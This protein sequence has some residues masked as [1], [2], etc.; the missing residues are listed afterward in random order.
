M[1]SQMKKSIFEE[2]TAKALKKWH[3]AAKQRKKLR[4]GTDTSM[5]SGDSTPTQGFSPLHLLH[6]HKQRSNAPE[7]NSIPL[8]PRSYASDTELEL[9]THGKREISLPHSSQTN[10]E[11]HNI[12]FSFEK[13]PDHF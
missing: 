10:T 7:S 1:G 2:Q 11:S 9:S 13:S 3:K 8:S 5:M 12:D 6:G 4:M